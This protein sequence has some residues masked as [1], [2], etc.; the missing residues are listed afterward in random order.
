MV[1]FHKVYVVK[2]I[3][4]VMNMLKIV[5]YTSQGLMVN[6][7][8]ACVK[9]LLVYTEISVSNGVVFVSVEAITECGIV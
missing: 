1:I 9:L 4:H 6:M 2:I 8:A 5:T 7:A 3:V